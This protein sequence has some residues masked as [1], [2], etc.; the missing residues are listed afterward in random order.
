MNNEPAERPKIL[1]VDDALDMIEVLIAQLGENHEINFSTTGRHALELAV[2]TLPDLILLDIIMPEMDGYAICRALKE[3]E[4]TCDIPV[5][6]LTCCSDN[7]DLVKGFRAGAVDYVTKPFQPN[8][9]L[10]RVTTH[11]QLR[12]ARCEVE[13]KNTELEKALEQNRMLVRE[14]YHRVKNNLNVACSLLNL[15]KD[16]VKDSRDASL[17]VEA[18]NRIMVMCGIHDLLC[19]SATHT[20]VPAVDFFTDITHKLL[21][22]Y[23]RREIHP[24]VECGDLC[25]DLNVAIT[26][27]LIVNELVTN[28][29][30]YAFPEGRK[31]NITLLLTRQG[32]GMSLTVRDDGVGIPDG[33]DIAT[34]DSL[35]LVLVTSLIQQ[36]GGTLEVRRKAGTA[37]IIS[38][39]VN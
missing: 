17:F 33:L 14:V 5:M 37:F 4:A 13:R 30:K 1:I 24:H 6:F 9:L 35:G 7:D 12:Q 11:L 16:L 15:Q 21:R 38:F 8:E 36:L 39:P 28:S 2:T 29:L 32:R 3:N 26:C 27:G 20:D 22:S 31:G 19:H 10:A 34:S 18:R 23:D 25:L